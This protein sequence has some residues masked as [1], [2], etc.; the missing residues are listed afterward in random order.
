MTAEIKRELAKIKKQVK[1]YQT[2]IARDAGVS[3]PLVS[4][5]LNGEF[6]D[7]DKGAKIIASARKYAVIARQDKMNR[8][9]K[10][11]NTILAA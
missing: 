5:V 11:A 4:R 3:Q 7:T 9:A 6:L 10:I 1:G 2:Q 8:Q